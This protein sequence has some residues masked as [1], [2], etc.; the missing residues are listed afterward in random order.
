MTKNHCGVTS[1]ACPAVG[2]LYNAPPDLLATSKGKGDKEEGNGEIG[3][4]RK[5]GVGIVWEGR[6]GADSKF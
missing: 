1:P 4:E 5:K 6:E 3:R 2:G